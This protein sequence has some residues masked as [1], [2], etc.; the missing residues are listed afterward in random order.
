MSCPCHRKLG[1]FRV[2]H[3]LFARTKPRTMRIAFPAQ[4]EKETMNAG[5]TVTGSTETMNDSKP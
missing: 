5:K 3:H 1:E 4:K 2:R